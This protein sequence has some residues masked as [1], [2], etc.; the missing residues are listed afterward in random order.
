MDQGDGSGGGKKYSYPRYILKVDWQ[1]LLM[2]GVRHV[3]LCVSV[4]ACVCLHWDPP[5]SQ[6]NQIVCMQTVHDIS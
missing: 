4:C 1:D 3:G 5:S 2:D 6:V